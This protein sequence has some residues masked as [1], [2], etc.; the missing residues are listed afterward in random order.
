MP[1]TSKEKIELKPCPFC[2]PEALAAPVITSSLMAIYAEGYW[3]DC[4]VCGISLEANEANTPEE[5]AK[6]WNTRPG[7]EQD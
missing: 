5:A 3:V 4:P 7:E 6:I 1:E 2:G